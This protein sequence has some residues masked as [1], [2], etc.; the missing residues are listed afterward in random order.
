MRMINNGTA[1]TGLLSPLASRFCLTIALIVTCLTFSQA[2]EQSRFTADVG[3]GVTPLSGK[4]SD[5]LETGWNIGVSG[6]V[7]LN[8]VFS[9]SLRYS[10]NGLGVN[11]SLL[12]RVGTPDG[13]SNLWSLTLDPKVQLGG[14]GRI[15][16]YAV[17]GVGYYR[18]TVDFTRPVIV[19][20]LFFDPFF[21]IAFSSLVVEDLSVKRVTK[22]GVGGNL[23]AGF[24]IKLGD[25]G[26]KVFSEA[27]YE[28][29]D[30]GNVP[31]RMIPVRFGL[32]W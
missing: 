30:T 25:S 16:P 13:H 17:G 32:R 10:F 26:V 12:Q 4:I 15:R 29:A 20:D 24:D 11:S 9:A 5:R 1:T 3:A 21:G 28:Y 22:G 6:G 2:Q 19:R 18:R 27:R 7:N 14:F 8:S 31:T 23:G